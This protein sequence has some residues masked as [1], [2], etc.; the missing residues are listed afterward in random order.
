[1]LIYNS[2]YLWNWNQWNFGSES[3]RSVLRSSHR[4]HGAIGVSG[5]AESAFVSVWTMYWAPKVSDQL[6]SV[7]YESSQSLPTCGG[8]IPELCW[9]CRLDCQFW[10]LSASRQH[11]LEELTH[12]FPMTEK[13]AKRVLVLSINYIVLI[14]LICPQSL[15]TWI[16]ILRPRSDMRARGCALASATFSITTLLSVQCLGLRT[17]DEGDLRTC[18]ILFDCLIVPLLRFHPL[19]ISRCRL[20]HVHIKNTLTAR[21][22]PSSLTRC[23]RDRSKFLQGTIHG[24]GNVCHNCPG[25]AANEQKPTKERTIKNKQPPIPSAAAPLRR[26][27]RYSSGIPNVSLKFSQHR[28]CVSPILWASISTVPGCLAADASHSPWDKRQVFG[29]QK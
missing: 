7:S 9:A 5:T 26:D 8:S 1:M 27:T 23:I 14:R 2:A 3:K 21:W 11:P 24:L 25:T 6:W 20:R 19:L 4:W 13:D 18:L 17:F 28:I 22:A 16:L 15:W 10:T 12:Y 29:G